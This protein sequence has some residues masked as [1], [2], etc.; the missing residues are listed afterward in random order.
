VGLGNPGRQYEGTRHNLGADVIALLADRHGERLKSSRP[1]RSLMAEARV[2]QR[3]LALAFPQT[4]VND[5]GVAVAALVRRF[6]IE[7][8]T[9]LVVVQD[10]LDLPVGAVRVKLGG[11]LAGHNGLR[12]IEAHL[13]DRGFARVRLGIDKAGG[14]ASGVSHVLGAPSRR[15][16]D[17]LATAIE[18]GADAVE[19]IL[20]EGIDVAMNRFN[21]R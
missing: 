2:G 15:D 3:R 4:Y 9:R 5:S 1:E 8:L 16:K 10:E 18:V 6:G 17:A 12:S 19:C 11:G 14:K 21:S 20:T 7:D 13:H